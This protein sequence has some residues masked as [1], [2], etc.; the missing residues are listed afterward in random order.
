[1]VTVDRK[2]KTTRSLENAHFGRYNPSFKCMPRCNVICISGAARDTLI[3]SIPV[4]ICCQATTSHLPFLCLEP[5]GLEY[6]ADVTKEIY[7][8]AYLK[9]F[10]ALGVING[11]SHI[12]IKIL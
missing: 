6:L 10:V 7:D 9:S 3:P 8:Y 5:H 4:V 12:G 1:V 11:H 2:V